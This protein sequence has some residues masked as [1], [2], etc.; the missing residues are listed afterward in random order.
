MA[1][2]STFELFP[3][4]YDG[5]SL[6]GS[7]LMM[8]ATKSKVA[9]IDTTSFSTLTF[10]GSNFKV[11]D[12]MI[13]S[14]TIKSLLITTDD[15]DK[16][17]T[18][19]GLSMNVGIVPGVTMTEFATGALTLALL[20]NN[21]VIGTNLADSLNFI[22]LA[23]NDIVFGK[24]GDDTLG[25]GTGKDVL[26]GGGGADQFEFTANMG[27]DKIRDFDADNGDGAQDLI[28][29]AFADAT[30]TAA[31]NGK[32]TIV[33]FGSGDRFILQGVTSTEINASDFTS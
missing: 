23:G 22:A 8:S 21:K 19:S 15:G 26:I 30:I 32:D 3:A 31:A 28:Y 4:S 27:T 17:I 12:G 5:A 20:G 18:L 25:G 7:L 9:C 29:A 16:A 14:G 24:G 10:S 13:T 1:K 33:D 6:G 11:N 2:R